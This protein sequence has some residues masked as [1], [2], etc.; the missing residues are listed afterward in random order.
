[1]NEIPELLPYIY[2][3]LNEDEH[4]S[5]LFD[6]NSCEKNESNTVCTCKIIVKYHDKFIIYFK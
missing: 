4:N 2:H 1:L 5:G 3:D 6:V